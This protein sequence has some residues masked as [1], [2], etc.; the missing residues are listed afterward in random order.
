MAEGFTIGI[1]SDEIDWQLKTAVEWAINNGV[2]QLEIRT[3][4]GKYIHLIDQKTAKTAAQL[5]RDTNIAVSCLASGFGK[6]NLKDKEEVR[7]HLESLKRLVEYAKI[8]G[9]KDIRAF[10]GWRDHDVPS[11]ADLLL[12]FFD[13]ALKILPDD[14]IFAVENEV[15]TNLATIYDVSLLR[16]TMDGDPRIMALYDP[17][18]N[19]YDVSRIASYE[20]ES[21][22]MMEAII[23]GELEEHADLIA[24]MHCK[25]TRNDGFQTDTVPLDD[26]RGIIDFAEVIQAL[27]ERRHYVPLDLEPHRLAAG[28]QL[29]HE[30]RAVP[31]G[32]GY[33]NPDNALCD[34]TALRV[35]LVD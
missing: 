21:W 17:G 10:G 5:L 4:D 20:G 8:F 24:I 29:D 18:N 12:D 11:I 31:G 22:S 32:E 3:V 28:E 23:Q 34:L 1:I 7:S 16:T 14:L 19:G 33:G 6:C 15:A 25:N 35:M 26:P 2:Y 30:V 13:K 27:I 9:T